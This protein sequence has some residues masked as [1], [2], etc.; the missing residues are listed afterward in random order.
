MQEGGDGL[1]KD[2]GKGR[3]VDGFKRYLR[4]GI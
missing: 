3:E 4:V 2:G 1:D